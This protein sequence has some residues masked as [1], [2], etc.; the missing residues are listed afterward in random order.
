MHVRAPPCCWEG[1]EHVNNIRIKIT[2][3]RSRAIDQYRY[4]SYQKGSRGGGASRECL[5]GQMDQELKKEQI[6]ILF[7]LV[8][9]LERFF[10]AGAVQPKFWMFLPPA[11]SFLLNN[12]LQLPHVYEHIHLKYMEQMP[13]LCISNPN[14]KAARCAQKIVLVDKESFRKQN[15]H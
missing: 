11:L 1:C 14:T 10:G 9:A 8:G 3:L 15:Y 5:A 4:G 13:S 2:I 12:Y 7:V 6:G